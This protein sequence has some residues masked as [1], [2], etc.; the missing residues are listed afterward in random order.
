VKRSRTVSLALVGLLLWLTG[1]T[2]YR[3]IPVGEAPEHGKVRVTSVSVGSTELRNPRV[4]ADSLK[5]RVG[6]YDY[7]IPLAGV[8]AVE[9]IGTDEVGTVFT[10]LG[11][12]ALGIV[13][14]A[15]AVQP[16][17]GM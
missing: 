11:L 4:E 7:T 17:F 3:V 2:S 16:D 6:N 13:V 8:S 12:L 1:C 15:I 14:A 9:A 10:V 5:G